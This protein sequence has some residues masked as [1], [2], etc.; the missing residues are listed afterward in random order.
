[1]KKQRISFPHLVLAAFSAAILLFVAGCET[2][3]PPGETVD[4]HEPGPDSVG[5]GPAVS[6]IVKVPSVTP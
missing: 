2:M 1:M 6:G 3:P 5:A 4:P